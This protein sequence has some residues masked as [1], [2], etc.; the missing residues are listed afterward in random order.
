MSKEQKKNKKPLLKLLH[1][2]VPLLSGLSTLAEVK[3]RPGAN[4]G[5][6]NS[7]PRL[8]STPIASLKKDSSE[9]LQKSIP[10]G[11]KKRGSVENLLK[12]TMS[13]SSSSGSSGSNVA[14]HLGGQR[15]GY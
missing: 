13:G 1:N 9:N 4:M 5:S 12:S 10:S 14:F 7:L 2:T 3:R 15:C 8:Q 11:G 6:T